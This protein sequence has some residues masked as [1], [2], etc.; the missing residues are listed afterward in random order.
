MKRILKILS[1][2]AAAIVISLVLRTGRSEQADAA[3]DQA[4]RTEEE[5]QNIE[6]Y[7]KTNKA[8]VNVS[9]QT[10]SFDFFGPVG[11][12][13]SGS[14]VIIDATNGYVVT[15]SH[16]ISNASKIAVTLASGT[17]HEVKIIGQDPDTEI[18]LLQILNPPEGL[19]AAELGTSSNLEVGQRVL[20][21][22]N[23]FG[24]NRTLTAGIISSL[25]RTIRSE[26]GRLI[27]DIIQTDAAINPGNSGGPLLDVA[28]RVVGL[29]T[30]IISKVGES[31]GISFAIPVDQIVRSLPQLQKYGKV[32][33]PMLGVRLL[34]TD[35]GLAVFEV[36]PEGPAGKAGIQGA[37]AIVQRGPYVRHVL[38]LSQ[39]DFIL[40][41]NG[42]EITSKLQAINLLDKAE[43]GKPITLIVRRGLQRNVGRK[44]E[45]TPQLG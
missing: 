2:L 5:R 9:V 11:Q 30:A 16:V 13:G 22:G 41:I 14:G 17:V 24:L 18:A 15:N 43:P 29:N 26:S 10:E 35:Y 4:P 37:H 21:I 34:A 33:R 44:L 28:G 39:A 42:E 20:A 27:E 32:L 6:V 8:V 31:S 25:G 7:R 23:P 3:T 45:I 36:D 1:I 19:V 38:D 40:A 12:Q